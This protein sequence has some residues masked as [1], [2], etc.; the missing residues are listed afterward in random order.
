M[1]RYQTGK[2]AYDASMKEDEKIKGSGSVF[3]GLRADLEGTGAA[4]VYIV[5]RDS[6]HGLRVMKTISFRDMRLVRLPG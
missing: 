5:R 1:T 6:R 3:Q 2:G 4:R